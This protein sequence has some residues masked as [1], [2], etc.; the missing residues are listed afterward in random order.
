M[1]EK[2][3]FQHIKERTINVNLKSV[4]VTQG[5]LQDAMECVSKEWTMPIVIEPRDLDGFFKVK[6]I[7]EKSSGV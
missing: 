6:V 7:E 5:G 2:S 3:Y 4:F 1:T